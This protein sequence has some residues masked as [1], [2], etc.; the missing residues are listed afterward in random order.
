MSYIWICNTL[1]TTLALPCR[2]QVQY[3]A[4]FLV[5]SLISIEYYLCVPLTNE[6]FSDSQSD[7]G[8][9]N[10]QTENRGSTNRKVEVRIMDEDE[11]NS[12]VQK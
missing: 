1:Q 12:K 8:N 10:R 6:A 5:C 9:K 4:S 11:S 7:A 3:A 2:T